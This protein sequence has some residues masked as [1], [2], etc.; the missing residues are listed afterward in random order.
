MSYSKMLNATCSIFCHDEEE[1]DGITR[2][3]PVLL[4]ENVRCRLVRKTAYG[5]DT[6]NS[7]GRA[8][9]STFY[10]LYLGKRVDIHN[11]DLVF[12]KNEK[13]IVQE[14]YQPCGHHVVV[15]LKKE[16]EA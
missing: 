7:K 16:G 4:R 6:S 11:G 8:V 1:Q 3:K 14:P 12:V 9:I 15:S 10:L 13:Y 5:A 2:N